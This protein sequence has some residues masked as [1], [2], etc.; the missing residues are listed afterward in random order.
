MGECKRVLGN[1]RILA[2]LAV[3]MVLNVCL[4]IRQ[5]TRY[6][7][8]DPAEYSRRYQELVRE[9]ETGD[10]ESQ[11]NTLEKQLEEASNV[12]TAYSLIQYREQ[13]PSLYELFLSSY[14]DNPDLMTMVETGVLPYSQKEASLRIAICNQMIGQLQYFIE[15]P[16]YLQKVKENAEQMSQ[17]SIFG[18][19]NSFSYKN[20]QKT[21]KDFAE[22]DGAVLSLGEDQAVT[23]LFQDK[24]ADYSIVPFQLL[25]CASLLEERKK[26][27]G[28]LSMPLPMG[29]CLWPLKGFFC[30]C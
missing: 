11:L 8:Y 7:V 3:L 26:D 28:V 16:Q 25:V 14:G 13:D 12:S 1:R 18:D 29:D 21:V 5:E 10:P 24:L 4:Y 23:S 22:M 2:V 19:P 30:Y 6:Q 27:F 20:I 9:C 17:V 15:Y